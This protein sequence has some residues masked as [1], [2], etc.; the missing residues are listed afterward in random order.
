VNK[1]TQKILK[2]QKIIRE[3]LSKN[4]LWPEVAKECGISEYHFHRIFSSFSGETP[5]DYLVRKRLEHAIARLAYCNN[6]DD[7]NIAELALDCGYS[8][9]ANLNKAFKN[10]FGVTPG[11][12]LNDKE[13][14]NSKIGKIKSKYGKEF[15]PNHLYPNE[16]LKNDLHIKEVKM[17]ATIKQIPKRRVAYKSSEQG[18]EKSSILT[19]WQDV[20]QKSA[21]LGRDLEEMEKY[22]IGH[23]NP[24]VTPIEK[25]RYDA[26]VLLEDSEEAPASLDQMDI[27]AGKFACFHYKGSGEKLLQ[28]YLEIY[29]N[30][31]SD[32]GQEPGNFPLIERYIFVDKDNPE[33]DIELETQFLLK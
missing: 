16:D 6:G 28:F 13:P 1:Y 25:C 15:H 21:I 31:F 17:K 5:R 12:V 27:P 8:S 11:E 30:W 4:V 26:C 23:D 14:K 9:Q 18:Y 10:Y 32:N 29:K 33:A 7:V 2:A 24:Q 19:T 3:N 22:G 20:M